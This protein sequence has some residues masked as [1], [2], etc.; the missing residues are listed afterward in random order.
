MESDVAGYGRGLICRII[1]HCL[2]GM[3]KATKTPGRDSK[4]PGKI[5]TWTLPNNK[6]Q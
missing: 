5:R 2:E 3:R 1:Q 4:S 6:G